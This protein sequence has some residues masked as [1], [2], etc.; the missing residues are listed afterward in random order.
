ML[1]TL[2]IKVPNPMIHTNNVMP[3]KN[4]LKLKK[5]P[6]HIIKIYGRPVLFVKTVFPTQGGPDVS[7]KRFICALVSNPSSNIVICEYLRFPVVYQLCGCQRDTAV[8]IL[9]HV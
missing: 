6:G 5:F 7:F 3:L 4:P 9:G 2:A 1:T 8:W